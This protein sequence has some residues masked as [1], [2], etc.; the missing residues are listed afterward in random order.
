[1]GY[2]RTVKT[3]SGATAVQIVWSSR[4]GSRSIEHLGSAHDEVELAALK[5][6]AAERL[7]AGQAVLDLGL[8]GPPGSEPLPITSSQMT[9]LW[10]GL[11]AV[12]RVLGFDVV[13]KGDNV[14]RDLVLARIIEP[15]S[16]VDA[17]RVL[18]EVGVEA[19]SYASR[20]YILSLPISAI[21]KPAPSVPQRCRLKLVRR[22][23]G[24]PLDG[25]VTPMPEPSLLSVLR[26]RALLSP[27][28]I[29]FT[30]IDYDQEWAGVAENLT[31]S[32]LYRRTL[33]V[34]HEVRLHGSTGDR[35]VILAP[36]GLDYIAA[37]LGSLQAGF[38]AVPLLAPEIGL[39]D[40]RERVSAV[41]ADASPSVILTTS[42][43]VG[44]V[45]DY[46]RRPNTVRQ[47]NT[48]KT[49]MFI[50]VDSLDL[51]SHNGTSEPAADAGG[52]AYLQYTSGSTRLPAGL[53]ISNHN[54]FTNFRQQM[55]AFFPQFQGL[56]PAD[57]T[58]VSWLPL[59]H[60][61]GLVLGVV[62][63]IMGGYHCEL[64]S[65]MSF[66]QQPVRWMQLLAKTSPTWSAAPNFAF[67]LAARKISDKDMAR[68]DLGR[69]T[70]II[71]GS[72]RVNPATLNRFMKRFAPYN[73]RNHVIRPSYGLA[74]ATLYVATRNSVDAPEVVYFESEKL[75]A[76]T[77]QRCEPPAGTPLPSYGKPQSPTVRIVDPD[78]RIECP[79]GTIG[80]LWVTG[81]NV[82]CGYWEKPEET[83][84]TFGAT[85]VA[86]TPG[87][88]EGPWLRTGDLGF[89]SQDEIF[90]LGRTKDLL[91]VYG[92]NHYPEDI[93]ATVHEITSGR[94]AAISVP[95]D[96][97]EHLVAIVEFTQEQTDS[98]AGQ[99][100]KLREI[101]RK[102]IS[103]VSN[104][105]G[106][107]VS[108]LVLV[109][110]G[111]IPLTTSGKV[112]RSAC[113]E[114]YRHKEF[115]RLDVSE[116]LLTEAW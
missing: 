69:V 66:L 73:L 85:L 89:V 53:M 96:R 41:L 51:E 44:G 100:P 103:A 39:H 71:N 1:M 45:A 32:Q 24:H 8:A 30:Y 115:K 23:N 109:P 60:D 63:P 75:S 104:S 97:T 87:T 90:I 82:A 86:P 11:C 25:I 58:I 48:G 54:L 36:Q 43:V 84:R 79:T 111:S 14:F 80:E 55:P 6:A 28:D 62:T 68:L 94:V 15:T 77:A 50:E 93:E 88:P 31:W 114:R 20:P 17:G 102:I 65:P 61:L 3:A 116:N 46:V 21:I 56:P 49:P 26:E 10:D 4:R 99:A 19:A 95:D 91:I 34:A 74:E 37:F 70:G 7:T 67:E 29:A 81:D 110:P 98:R 59:Y 57:T 33:N 38:I 16:K 22:P 83:E 12:Y 40:E 108:D 5:A 27:N 35:A 112:R 13:A 9:Y 64:T 47:P 113:A 105:H 2:V 18:D 78:T 52:I 72:E 42:A 106:L 76:G 101:R 92:R 107:H